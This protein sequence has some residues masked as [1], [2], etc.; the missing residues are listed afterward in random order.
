MTP[1][2]QTAPKTD[3]GKELYDLLRRSYGYLQEVGKEFKAVPLKK[4]EYHKMYLYTLQLLGIVDRD[5][6]GKEKAE[7][8]RFNIV[9]WVGGILAQADLQI[10]LLIRKNASTEEKERVRK[11]SAKAIKTVLNFFVDDGKK[12]REP[13]ELTASGVLY[14]YPKYTG[15]LLNGIAKGDINDAKGMIAF[16]QQKAEADEKA[17]LEGEEKP[18]KPVEQATPAQTLEIKNIK[19]HFNELIALAAPLRDMVKKVAGGLTLQ[20]GAADEAELT[21]YRDLCIEFMQSYVSS[22]SPN[23]KSSISADLGSGKSPVH[24]FEDGLKTAKAIYRAISEIVK[25]VQGKRKAAGAE[26]A[27]RTLPAL[28]GDAITSYESIMG[29]IEQK[30]R[31]I[32]EKKNIGE[33]SEL[34]AGLQERF[35]EEIKR[36]DKEYLDLKFKFGT[37]TALLAQAIGSNKQ[38]AAGVEAQIKQDSEQDVEKFLT[39]TYI[40][41]LTA[42]RDRLVSSLKRYNKVFNKVFNK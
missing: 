27:Y 26:G 12:Q 25:F 33:L 34:L 8:I 36:L 5:L 19:A 35:D 1:K 32:G 20:F 22:M 11:D 16:A 17:K 6:A 38:L 10:S 7:I 40:S 39:I 28:T 15:A 2:G 18:K 42:E 9:D 4:P 3:A 23:T 31:K 24:G 37:D 30:G 14:A 41:K 21:R 29:A 13:D